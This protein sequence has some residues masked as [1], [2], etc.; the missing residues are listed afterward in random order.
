MSIVTFWNDGR[1]QSG[2]TLTSVAIATKMAIER[3]YKILLLSTS[4]NDPTMKNCF[5]VNEIQRNL[6]IFGNKSNNIA[7]ENGIEGLSKLIMSNKLTPNVITDYTKVIFK[8]RLEVISGYEGAKDKT[9]EQKLDDYRKMEECYPE[10]I[11]TANQYYDMVIVDVDKLLHTSVKEEILRISNVNVYVFLQKLSSLNKYNELKQIDQEISG[12]KA[13]PVI[14][15]YDKR[16]KYNI[17]NVTK[18][19]GIKKE[20]N[21]IPDNLLF[22][23]AAEEA[24]VVDLFLRLK[25]VKDTTDDNYIFTDHILKLMND[26]IKRLQELQKKMR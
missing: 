26:I 15:R 25:N 10:L 1:E 20:L 21:V 22:Y 14:G 16:T 11:R 3:N 4:F 8:G 17:K 13:I 5:G 2:K 6:K 12:P 9:F 19:L 23:E 7:V 24:N 18:Y